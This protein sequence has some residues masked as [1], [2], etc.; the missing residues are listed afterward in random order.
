MDSRSYTVRITD[1]CGKWTYTFDLSKLPYPSDI[2]FTKMS[3]TYYKVTWNDGSY[4]D[5]TLN[6]PYPA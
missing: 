3:E 4:T 1:Y 2:G 6:N 5:F